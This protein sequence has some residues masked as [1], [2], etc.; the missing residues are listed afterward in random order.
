MLFVRNGQL[1]ATLSATACQ[2]TATIGSGHSLT[3]TVLVVAAT[4][5]RLKCS[6]HDLY[7]VLLLFT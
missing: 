6:F 3:E 4:V 1:F 7:I 5:V 2:Y